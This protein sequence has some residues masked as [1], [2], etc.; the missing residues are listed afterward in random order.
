MD[1]LR[2]GR[3]AFLHIDPAAAHALQAAQVAPGEHLAAYEFGVFM[4]ARLH[5]GHVVQGGLADGLLGGHRRQPGCRSRAPVGVL[6]C[7]AQADR[8]VSG[9]VGLLADRAH[10]NG[11][12]ALVPHVSRP[13]LHRR[14]GQHRLIAGQPSRQTDVLGMRMIILFLAG[15]RGRGRPGPSRNP[16]G[17]HRVWP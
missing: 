9:R 3:V 16:G 13:H 14:H 6:P 7:A 11:S 12:L 5:A 8:T 2:A 17:F 4:A 15:L 10:S 1:E